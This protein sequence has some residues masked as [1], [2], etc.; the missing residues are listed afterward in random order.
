MVRTVLT[1]VGSCVVGIGLTL[2]VQSY[3]HVQTVQT[4]TVTCPEPP[5]PRAVTGEMDTTYTPQGRALRMPGGT[6]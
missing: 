4:A 1:I 2:S 3:T 5:P 6:R